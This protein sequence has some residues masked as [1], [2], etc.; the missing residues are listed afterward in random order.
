M[1][2]AADAAVP[3]SSSMAFDLSMLP[4]K[5]YFQNQSKNAFT[6]RFTLLQMEWD[7]YGQRLAHAIELARVD[8]AKLATAIGVSVQAVG[9]VIKGVTKALTA[10]NSAR[11]ARFLRVDHF[12]LATGEGE[13]RPPGL[14][15]EATS[16]A[17]RYDKLSEAGRAK[18]S[19]AIV[20]AQDGVPDA[21][22]EQAMP[23]TATKAK[24]KTEP[25][26]H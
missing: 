24:A 7:T 12:W 22:V 1:A 5:A 19:A 16:F 15:E 3:P 26:N 14:T 25:E 10:D 6:G 17:R 8:R 18:F 11:A 4:I 2:A 13:P 21:R 20:I 23:I 9:Q